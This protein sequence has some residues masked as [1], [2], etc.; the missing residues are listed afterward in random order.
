MLSDLFEGRSQLF[1]KHF[2][3]GPGVQHQCV[4][5]SLEVDH[6]KGLLEHLNNHDVT[7]AVLARAPIE[8]IEA[9]RKRMGWR[10]PWVSSYRSDFNFD[11][12]SNSHP[13][14]LL[15]PRHLPA[16]GWTARRDLALCGRSQLLGVLIARAES[17]PL[18]QILKERIFVPLQHG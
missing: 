14:R 4:G 8:K 3:M 6:V 18:A 16:P 17:K 5:C 1:I 7:Y 2:M 12:M 13:R 11:L 15:R 9:V 10:F